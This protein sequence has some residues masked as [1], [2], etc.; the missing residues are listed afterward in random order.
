[1]A[2][3]NHQDE[4]YEHYILCVMSMISTPGG[5]PRTMAEIEVA[6]KSYEHN[7]NGEG[8]SFDGFQTNEAPVKC[9]VD[10]G[11]IEENPVTHII[12][13]TSSECEQNEAV[14]DDNGQILTAKDWF[15][16]SIVEFYRD[17]EEL[18]DD[19]NP[20]LQDD[21]FRHLP[22]NGTNPSENLQIL[23]S[24]LDECPALI[25]ID[26]TGGPRDAAFL[27]TSVVQFIEAKYAGAVTQTGKAS[28]KVGLGRTVY[29]NWGEE[30]LHLQNE[31][32]ALNHLIR[33]IT[34][35]TQHGVAKPLS[36]YFVTRDT[37]GTDTSSEMKRLC[38]AME[39]FSDD[40]SLC[41]VSRI[42]DDVEVVVVE[43]LGA[44]FKGFV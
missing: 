24:V 22:Y 23:I 2:G 31:T 30:R 9:L 17:Y 4:R 21:F 42:N 26:T 25:D 44:D 10:L 27:L 13:L 39:S 6:T 1:M 29:S 28:G 7:D 37:T 36:D 41:R 40:L 34:A 16:R 5:R 11:L 38:D 8:L 19:E 35:F 15:E 32:F 20:A 33:A 12:C 43:V 3:N 18:P 14:V